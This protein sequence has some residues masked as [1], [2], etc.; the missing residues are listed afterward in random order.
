MKRFLSSF[1]GVVDFRPPPIEWFDVLLSRIPPTSM[2]ALLDT[3]TA[4]IAAGGTG[5][6]LA[7]A[8]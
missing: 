5:V 1:S 4:T 7:V 8:M 2:D 6:L 3:P